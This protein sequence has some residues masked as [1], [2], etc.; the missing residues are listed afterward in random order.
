MK[1]GESHEQNPDNMEGLEERGGSQ[2]E[3]K[4]PSKLKRMMQGAALLAALA[5][6]YTAGNKDTQ[7]EGDTIA[8]VF[9]V[10]SENEK[11]STLPSL[12]NV[13]IEEMS[14]GKLEELAGKAESFMNQENFKNSEQYQ[15]FLAYVEDVQSLAD[16]SRSMSFNKIDQV[17]NAKGTRARAIHLAIGHGAYLTADSHV[18]VKTVAGIPIKIIIDGKSIEFGNDSFFDSEKDVLIKCGI[19]TYEE[20]HPEQAEAIAASLEEVDVPGDGK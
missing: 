18:E 13:S 9:Q 5:G 17:G 10:D 8:G 19:D 11:K 2:V 16:G 6:A 14:E 3:R 15:D 1:F 20:A 7:A 4:N 12:E